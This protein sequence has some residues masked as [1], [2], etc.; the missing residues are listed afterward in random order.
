MY[1]NLGNLVW[2]GFGPTG[3]GPSHNFHVCP[4]NGTD[5]LCYFT[6]Y[7]DMGYNRGHAMI[8]NNRLT[9][10]A[11]VQSQGG[12]PSNDQHEFN[13]VDNG[14]SAIVTVYDPVQYDMSHWNITTGQGWLM[15]SWFQEIEIAT[16]DLL[17]EWDALSHIS[18]NQSYVLP[19]ST[20]VS[21]T[22][23]GPITP[24][25]APWD[26]FHIN[27]ID[28]FAN[29]D[30]LISGRHVSAV[31][32][33]SGSNGNVLWQLGGPLSNFSMDHGF[34]FTFQ[35]DARIIQENT[36]TTI[37]SLFDNAS[38]QFNHSSRYS[39]GKIIKIDLTKNHASLLKTFIAPNE[40]TSDSQGNCQVFDKAN[41]ET[42][43]VFCGWGSKA[44]FSEYTPDGKLVQTGH[45]AY[46]SSMSYR[47]F[48][49][50]YT[51][52]P[53]DAPAAWV[54]AHNTSAQTTYYVSWNG[55]TEV[56][57]W[58]IYSGLAKDGP[59]SVVDTVQKNGFETTFTAK[60]YHA[61]TLIEAVDGSGQ[62]IRNMTRAVRTFVPGTELAKVCDA[63]SC[64]VASGFSKPSASG[65]GNG[66][67]NPGAKGP[68]SGAVALKGRKRTGVWNIPCISALDS[69]F[70]LNLAW[71]SV[72]L[73]I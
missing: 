72:V 17:F 61:W 14:K 32:R 35:H 37:I 24:P 44:V 54:Y 31:Y 12:L 64:P 13:V 57:S 48:K 21:G 49:F 25:D 2:S 3:S 16:G 47:N 34:N 70:L 41:W 23:L 20:D 38:N 56:R 55:A 18:V 5:Q 46:A 71:V 15:N 52:N 53:T 67:K 22:G 65:S 40:L 62:G 36:T 29:G 63:Y 30:Y 11:S 45:F 1:D 27:S 26:F 6:G 28:K 43:N 9:T 60:G 51:T 58:K 69:A 33:I 50:N 66:T 7:Q 42:S 8:M 73:C 39:S 10:I 19:N 4:I 68:T 59:W